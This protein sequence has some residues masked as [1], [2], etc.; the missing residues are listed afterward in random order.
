VRR[1]GGRED[2]CR[3]HRRAASNVAAAPS[4]AHRPRAAIS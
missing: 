1:G 4:M 3:P 2:V